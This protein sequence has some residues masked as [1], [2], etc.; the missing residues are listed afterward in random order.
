M[1]AGWKIF[2]L[3]KE[4]NGNLGPAASGY[5]QGFFEVLVKGGR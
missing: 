3:Q 2:F 4:S 5:G 1:E